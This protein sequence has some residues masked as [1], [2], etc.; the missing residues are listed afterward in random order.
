MAAGLTA[1]GAGRCAAAAGPDVVTEVSVA[2]G[3][4][5]NAAL[6]GV[7]GAV[8][9]RLPVGVT[10]H[11]A[12]ITREATVVIQGQGRE[13]SILRAAADV[14]LIAQGDLMQP[15][16]GD[17][18]LSDFTYDRAH[19][20]VGDAD[21]RAIVASNAGGDVIFRHFRVQHFNFGGQL[22]LFF[23]GV[24]PAVHQAKEESPRH[25]YVGFHN[26]ILDYKTGGGIRNRHGGSGGAGQIQFNADRFAF[27]ADSVFQGHLTQHADPAQ[28]VG[29]AKRGNAGPLGALHFNIWQHG[30]VAGEFR[31][32][33]YAV[34]R[35][36]GVMSWDGVL[37]IRAHCPD[38]GFG[39]QFWPR[40]Y[41]P[42]P[43]GHLIFDGVFLT[44]ADGN[45]W[46][47]RGFKAMGD[48][49]S[50]TV[51]N[52]FLSGRDAPIDFASGLRVGQ[53]RQGM[54]TISDTIIVT[55]RAGVDIGSHDVILEGVHINNLHVR[56]HPDGAGFFRQAVDLRE[57]PDSPGA[58]HM[59]ANILADGY[60]GNIVAAAIS[61]HSDLVIENVRGQPGQAPMVTDAYPIA[62][63]PRRPLP[64]GTD[65]A[66]AAAG[67]TPIATLSDFT[68]AENFSKLD[69]YLT[70]HDLG[71]YLMVVVGTESL[72]NR[73]PDLRNTF[74][75]DALQFAI[76]EGLPGE[77]P[78][79]VLFDLARHDERGL[80]VYRRNRWTDRPLSSGLL[81][82]EAEGIRL[83]VTHDPVRSEAVYQVL[84]P[85]EAI[86]L[87]APWYDILSVD[88]AA[89]KGATYPRIAGTSWP[90]PYA[91][92]QADT[93]DHEVSRARSG[94]IFHPP[95][96][97]TRGFKAV[98]CE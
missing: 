73:Q 95:T 62:T 17:L 4:T 64:I 63:I 45:P 39:D 86:G 34:V 19:R 54:V 83:A 60:L 8:L 87:P 11:D 2:P 3:Q 68:N 85:W 15:F 50:I 67:L 13:V 36:G 93:E 89:T 72:S 29:E 88:L 79:Y 32:V 51:R 38:A 37:E 24:G 70:H 78:G 20:H 27:D 10:E 94:G 80:H 21:P 14:P 71:V 84:L 5:L 28:T 69:V 23:R 49:K 76:T 75:G 42:G 18:V 47:D 77:H 30:L 40:A 81:D 6:E 56:P 96:V 12:P 90:S 48:W 58:T 22:T 33:D 65:A 74:R 91:S 35:Y 1:S 82:L 97:A 66:A 7:A 43:N 26:A 25:R 46:H 98:K 9:V 92:L 44:S 41:L 57:A 16:A 55:R 52:C 59:I 31:E 61:P 53:Q